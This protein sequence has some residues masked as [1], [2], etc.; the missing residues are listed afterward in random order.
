MS[1]WAAGALVVFSRPSAHCCWQYYPSIN[2]RAYAPPCSIL[3]TTGLQ[4]PSFSLSLLE[5]SSSA[6]NADGLIHSVPFDSIQHHAI[7]PVFHPII[8]ASA[9]HSWSVHVQISA[10]H[11]LVN[12][13]WPL[14]SIVI[15]L[16]GNWVLWVCPGDTTAC[17]AYPWQI[18]IPGWAVFREVPQALCNPFI[19]SY[20]VSSAVSCDAHSHRT[21]FW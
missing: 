17:A 1:S 19:V 3:L 11:S 13:K 16:W 15:M 2:S 6:V 9:S 21:P 4:P 7:Y 8:D 18:L 5:A 12:C 14:C 20:T 10:I